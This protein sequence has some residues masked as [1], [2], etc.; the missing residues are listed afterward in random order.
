MYSRGML[1]YRWSNIYLVGKERMESLDCAKTSLIT[2]V[3]QDKAGGHML[4]KSNFTILK[5]Y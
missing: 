3:D 5:K 4:R 2:G 1:I